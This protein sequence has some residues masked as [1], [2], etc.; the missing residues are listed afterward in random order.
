VDASGRAQPDAAPRGTGPGMR[1]LIAEPCPALAANIPLTPR[2]EDAS[3]FCM[4]W[5]RIRD[6]IS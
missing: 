5:T 6:A 3:R 1:T 2:V 4:Q